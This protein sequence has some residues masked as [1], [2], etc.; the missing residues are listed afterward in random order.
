MKDFI[1]TGEGIVGPSWIDE[2]DHMNMMWYTYLIDAA[3]QRLLETAKIIGAESAQRFVAARV[4][5]AHRRELR[6]GAP[7]ATWSGLLEVSDKS[8][9]CAHKITSTGIVAARSEITIV[10]FDEQSRRSTVFSADLVSRAT[11][12][13][14]DGLVSSR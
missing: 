5:T 9:T 12:Y 3:T 13:L 1:L 4:A 10:P 2:N 8:L 6:L 11:P 14:V 7:W